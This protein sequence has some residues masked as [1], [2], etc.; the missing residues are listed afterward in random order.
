MNTPGVNAVACDATDPYSRQPEL[1]H[2]A[3]RISKADL[4][5]PLAIVR[6]CANQADAL[7]LLQRVRQVLADYP[8]AAVGLYGRNTPLVVLRAATT[9]ALAD[10]EIA[11]LD[12]L[13]GIEGND[14]AI[15]YADAS[16]RIAKKAVAV[17]GRLQAVRLCGETLAI[18]WLK[19]AMAEDELD[20]GLIRMAL[21]PSSRAPVSVVPRNIVCKCADVTDVQIRQ[22]LAAGSSLPVLQEKLRCGTFCGSCLPAIRHM[23][24]ECPPAE[25]VAA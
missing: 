19:Q 2:A 13:F 23:V 21:A 25:A 17:D 1:K 8:Y 24:A 4:P 9:E 20:A 15:V 10:A 12:R 5:Y 11:A 14:G 3:V 22:E 16:K 7:A 18:S 6:R